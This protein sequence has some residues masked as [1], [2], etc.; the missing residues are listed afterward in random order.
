MVQ[1]DCTDWDFILSRTQANGKVCIC[2]N[3]ELKIHTPDLSQEAITTITYGN[4]LLSFDAEMD[5]RHQFASVTSRN[6]DIAQQSIIEKTANRNNF[7]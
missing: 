4:N 6:W 7:V 2:N 1:Y 5:A 3:G